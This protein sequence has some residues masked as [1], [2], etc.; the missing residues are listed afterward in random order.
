MHLPDPILLYTGLR[1]RIFIQ[2]HKFT[3]TDS[4]PRLFASSSVFNDVAFTGKLIIHSLFIHIWV[5]SFSTLDDLMRCWIHIK[6][7]CSKEALRIKPD[8]CRLQELSL[9]E[10]SFDSERIS[11]F[12]ISE[13]W[14]VNYQGLWLITRTRQ[15]PLEPAEYYIKS[16]IKQE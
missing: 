3:F 6:R 5:C 16:R 14:S 9:D 13:R 15:E 12:L 4:L 2:K 11:A 7:F 1:Y 10:F 8:I